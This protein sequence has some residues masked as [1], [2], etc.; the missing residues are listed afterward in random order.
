MWL[1]HNY[2]VHWSVL[3]VYFQWEHQIQ[4]VKCTLLNSE[5]TYCAEALKN[6]RWFGVTLSDRMKR[7]DKLIYGIF[8]ISV[9]SFKKVD[10][11]KQSILQRIK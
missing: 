10:I 4:E 1:F 11:S 5:G 6:G 2:I 9:R 7:E 3:S 8:H